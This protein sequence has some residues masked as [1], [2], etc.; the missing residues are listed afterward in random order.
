MHSL[1]KSGARL[2]RGHPW[3]GALARQGTA[4]GHRSPFQDPKGEQGTSS[5]P[6][7]HSPGHALA[8]LSPLCT[9]SGWWLFSPNLPGLP[10]A[11]GG[12]V[13]PRAVTSQSQGLS[14]VCGGWGRELSPA[15]LQLSEPGGS[16]LCQPH[17]YPSK[18][19]PSKA[20][21][22]AE[23]H[24]A[25]HWATAFHGRQRALRGRN[26]RSSHVLRVYLST[27]GG[28]WPGKATGVFA[29]PNPVEARAGRV[30]VR[31][32]PKPGEGVPGAGSA[33]PPCSLCS[34]EQTPAWLL[35]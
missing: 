4:G 11:G 15:E 27:G 10:S 7:G 6:H 5:P 33:S 31:E 24:G 34:G 16:R 19:W 2:L 20:N 8:A 26:G 23:A 1:L 3:A 13:E 25:V 9:Q 32:P 12:G 21:C 17:P 22:R 29:K 14:P 28:R 30:R 35:F 18:A